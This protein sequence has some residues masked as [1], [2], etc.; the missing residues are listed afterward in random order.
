MLYVVA[1]GAEG[2]AAPW[3]GGRN[4]GTI[5]TATVAVEPLVKVWEAPD[6]RVGGQAAPTAGL[7]CEGAPLRREVGALESEHRLRA[8]EDAHGVPALGVVPRLDQSVR[9]V[10][11]GPRLQ[12]EGQTESHGCR[13]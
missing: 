6:Q 4:E 11:L 2:S 3:A 8:V 13:T 10:E 9:A 5:G 12:H 1:G 7:L